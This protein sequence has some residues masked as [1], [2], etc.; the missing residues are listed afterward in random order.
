MMSSMERDLP[1][2]ELWGLKRWGAIRGSRA[3]SSKSHDGK[4]QSQA[5]DECPG[6][7]QEEVEPAVMVHLC[8]DSSC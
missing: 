4:D 6:A 5:E 3:G 1:R 7:N 8:Q 2:A